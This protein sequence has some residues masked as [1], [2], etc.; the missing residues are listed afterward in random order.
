LEAGGIYVMLCARPYTKKEIVKREERIR[1]ALVDAGL[2]IDAAQVQFRDSSQ[3]AHWVNAHPPVAVWVLER[4]QPGLIGPFRGWTHWA[5]RHEHDSSPWVP[6]PRLAPLR[7]ELRK[8]LA[9]PRGVARVVGLSGV[10]K[11]RLVLEALGPIDDEETS[12]PRL[13]DLVL[14]AVES[15]AGS[16]TVKNIIQNL[17]DASVRAVVVVDRCMPEP[18][19]D[20]AAMVK[21]SSSQLSLVTIDDEIPGNVR[22]S[23]D[24]LLVEKAEPE[25][26]DR[27]LKG[28][29]PNLP[30]EDHRRLLKF[31]DGF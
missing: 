10:G 4:T 21:R 1:K 23:P 18:H 12:K 7:E 8:L 11:S 30:A 17:A 22:S 19:Q 2:A 14:Y 28:V 27:L 25:V 6:D 3:I 16:T 29:A 15:E 26:I 31:S 20:I 24:T 5:G 9:A 13:S